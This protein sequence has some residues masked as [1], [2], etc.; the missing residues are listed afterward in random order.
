M[1]KLFQKL[2][3]YLFRPAIPNDV[4]LLLES[5]SKVFRDAARS[6][7]FTQLSQQLA[8]QAE[9]GE[10]EQLT[11]HEVSLKFVGRS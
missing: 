8:E 5:P 7:L 1:K 3:N 2:G 4:R 10:I 9:S 6:T 11:A